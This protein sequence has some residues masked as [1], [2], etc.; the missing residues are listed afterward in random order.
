MDINELLGC[1]SGPAL[2]N[3]N[4]IDRQRVATKMWEFRKQF[5]ETGSKNRLHKARN[6]FPA[7]PKLN[8]PEQLRQRGLD[9]LHSSH[10][11][12]PPL[13]CGA[14]DAWIENAEYARYKAFSYIDAAA[15]L[16]TREAH[17]QAPN[18][19]AFDEQYY[20]S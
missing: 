5:A 2:L 20:S 11:P 6:L 12:C 4:M 16:E 8:N 9:M 3:A 10:Q 14:D 7:P 13:P 18:L 1:I 15:I 19:H 17:R